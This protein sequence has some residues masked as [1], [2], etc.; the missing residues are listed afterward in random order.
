MLTVRSRSST[1]ATF[2][3]LHDA[4]VPT[5]ATGESLEQEDARAWALRFELVQPFAP[6]G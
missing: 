5:N 3:D 4:L 2:V 6:L 1:S